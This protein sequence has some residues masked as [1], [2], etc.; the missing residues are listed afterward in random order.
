MSNFVEQMAAKSTPTK[1]MQTTGCLH[2]RH[3]QRMLFHHYLSISSGH[4]LQRLPQQPCNGPPLN[5]LQT[6][7]SLIWKLV[8]CNDLVQWGR[9][10]QTDPEENTFHL[11]FLGEILPRGQQDHCLLAIGSSGQS[12]ATLPKY[13]Q[14]LM[15]SMMYR[16]LGLLGLSPVQRRRH[17]QHLL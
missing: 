2:P 7:I 4:C 5:I 17:R 1:V 15:I 12:P 16:L 9:L 6:S 14:S 10:A 3:I 8:L 13:L 11:L